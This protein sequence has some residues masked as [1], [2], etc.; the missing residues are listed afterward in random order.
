MAAED[1]G[2]EWLSAF[3]KIFTIEDE[4]PHGNAKQRQENL[5]ASQDKRRQ[6]NMQLHLQSELDSNMSRLCMFSL[7][8]I[9]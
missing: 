2:C 6:R 1:N 4:I 9:I 5:V 8:D 7:L 3:A